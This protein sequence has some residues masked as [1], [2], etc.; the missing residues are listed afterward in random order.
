MYPMYLLHMERD[1]DIGRKVKSLLKCINYT[2]RG[3]LNFVIFM[4]QV[5]S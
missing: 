5:E 1:D 3:V 2:Y 4:G